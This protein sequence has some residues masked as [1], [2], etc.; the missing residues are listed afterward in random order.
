ML[1]RPVFLHQTREQGQRSPHSSPAARV[2]RPVD[3]EDESV[4]VGVAHERGQQPVELLLCHRVQLVLEA[5]G[6]LASLE[7]D[8]ANDERE[9]R[10]RRNGHTAL[11]LGT[12]HD[13]LSTVG[14]VR[15]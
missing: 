7:H 6:H 3:R 5:R 10:W 8:H 4:L 15:R 11:D 9:P 1:H 12:G 13:G 2:G 14:P